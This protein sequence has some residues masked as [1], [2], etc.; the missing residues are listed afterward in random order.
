MSFTVISTFSGCGG[1]SLGYKMAG[2]KMLLAVEWDDDAV[3][4]YRLNFPDTP[5]Y[6]GDIAKLSVEEALSRTG[7][8]PGELDIFDGSPP[9][10]GFS[11]AGKREFGDDR[12]QLFREYVRLLRGL[13]PKT[14]VMENVSGMVK[15]N[16]KL[17]FAEILT[18]LKA[19][20]YNVSAR[21]MNAM[22]YGV[23]QSRERM[24]FIGVRE[25]FGVQP[26]HPVGSSRLVMPRKLDSRPA[27]YSPRRYGDELCSERKPVGTITKI[28]RK[29]WS[30]T[31]EFGI[32]SYSYAG[33]FPD[34]FEFGTLENAKNRIGNCV[35]PKL[36]QAVASHIYQT[37]LCK[38]NDEGKEA[39]ADAA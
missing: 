12:N 8:K 22:H 29:F 9:C 5:I 35:P 14:F 39:H 6:H 3:A 15:G 25:G 23:P 33:S 13:K 21:L 7:L 30:P 31:E 17:M 28:G 37:I 1:S 10:Q 4:T 34:W 19:S 36:M 16:M 20:G 18:E 32:K 24:I 11:T 38:L 26:T 27:R 2:G